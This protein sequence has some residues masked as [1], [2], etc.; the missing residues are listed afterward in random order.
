MKQARDILEKSIKVD[1]FSDDAKDVSH[2]KGLL[3]ELEKQ[4]KEHIWK[5]KQK[6]TQQVAKKAFIGIAAIGAIAVLTYGAI[7]VR[8]RLQR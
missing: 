1:G 3:F 8:R 7:C 2:F 5:Q 6:N 4:M